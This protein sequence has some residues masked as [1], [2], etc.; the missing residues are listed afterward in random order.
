M[1][2]ILFFSV[3]K[4]CYIIGNNSK[5]HILDSY[6]HKVYKTVY[7]NFLILSSLYNCFISSC[8]DGVL[9]KWEGLH[10]KFSMGNEGDGFY[11]ILA[12]LLVY[13]VI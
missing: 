2:C 13:N 11:L 10:K 12:V 6:V 8:L 4:C 7:F 1:K 9:E 5:K 3:Y